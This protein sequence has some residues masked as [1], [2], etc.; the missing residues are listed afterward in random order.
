MVI[1]GESLEAIVEIVITRSFS[2]RCEWTVLGT[3]W[4]VAVTTPMGALNSCEQGIVFGMRS[5]NGATKNLAFEP[6]WKELEQQ[7]QAYKTAHSR[8]YGK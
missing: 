7:L 8:R 2:Y 5:M 6:L 3:H 1:L 4:N